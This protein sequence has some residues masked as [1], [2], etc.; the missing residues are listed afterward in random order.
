MPACTA[1]R[2]IALALV[3]HDVFTSRCAELQPHL[4]CL[5]NG[6]ATRARM[7]PCF[8]SKVP[9]E[10]VEEMFHAVDQLC[11]KPSG[12]IVRSFPVLATSIP[13][14]TSA[15]MW[16]KFSRSIRMT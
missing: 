1:V 2:A 5:P 4:L 7:F 10:A 8:E 11:R 16:P 14:S 9:F 6:R 15:K 3:L 12:K 13:T